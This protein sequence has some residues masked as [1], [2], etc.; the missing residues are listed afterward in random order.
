M[1]K[2]VDI[3]LLYAANVKVVGIQVL[4]ATN[5]KLCCIQVLYATKLD[6]KVLYPT[7]IYVC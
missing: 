7:N 6:T 1:L 2:Y 4:Y 5:V 3:R